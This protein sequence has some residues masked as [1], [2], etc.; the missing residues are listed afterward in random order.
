MGGTEKHKS[1]F[2]ALLKWS[3]KYG[4]SLSP[5]DDCIFVSFNSGDEYSM[6]RLD[7]NY[8]PE[9]TRYEAFDLGDL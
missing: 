9:V 5:G 1:A 3:E 6:N 4:A 8:V 7:P 2:R